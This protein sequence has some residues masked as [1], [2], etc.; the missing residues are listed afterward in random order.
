MKV[1]RGLLFLALFLGVLVYRVEP[2]CSPTSYYKNCWIR[3]FPGI[4]IDT[5]ESGRRGASLVRSY[6]EESALRCGRS[7][8]LS[9]NVS[10]NVA[11][12]D[13]DA[14]QDN[15][16]HLHCP[17]LESCIIAHRDKVVLYNVTKGVDPDLLVF[18]KHLTSNVRVLPHHFSRVNASEVQPPSDKRQFFHPPPPATVKQTTS[19]STTATV[20]RPPTATTSGIFR[21][22]SMASPSVTVTTPSSRT[23]TP[24]PTSLSTASKHHTFSTSTFKPQTSVK[25]Q[26]SPTPGGEDTMAGSVAGWHSLLVALLSCVAVLLLLGCCC[27]VLVSW[28]RRGR[29]MRGYRTSEISGSMRLIKYSVVRERS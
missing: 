25:E 9:R 26:G 16:L 27:C 7:C 22:T 4:L 12:F 19:S 23:T 15:C 18:G 28:R 3:H 17:T 29:G 11:I 2:R 8:C 5:E 10:C 20:K 6:Q 24:P 13:Y 1:S 14:T 21:T